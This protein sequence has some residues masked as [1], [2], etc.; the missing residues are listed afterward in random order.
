[1]N[2]DKPTTN[3]YLIAGLKGGVSAIPL[4]GGAITEF[5]NLTIQTPLEK[6]R[7]EWIESLYEEIQTLKDKLEKFKSDQLSKNEDYISSFTR[8]SQIAIKTHDKEKLDYLRNAVINSVDSELHSFEQAIFL[9]CLDN[10]TIGHINVLKDIHKMALNGPRSSSSEWED[11]EIYKI[12]PSIPESTRRFIILDL[13]NKGFLTASYIMLD[14]SKSTNL[15][16]NC[17]EL[18][19]K[20]IVFLKKKKYE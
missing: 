5:M 3:D 4:V 9:N 15:S 10:F 11:L 19:E 12:S 2:K 14:S 1:M 13:K 16:I 8:A 6:R 17:S 20:F 18:G 7:K